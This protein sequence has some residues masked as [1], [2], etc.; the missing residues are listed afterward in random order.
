MKLAVYN[1]VAAILGASDM[2][3]G[4]GAVIA[5]SVRNGRQEVD[6]PE[7]EQLAKHSS[8]REFWAEE[9]GVGRE[10]DVRG[11]AGVL[12]GMARSERP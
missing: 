9:T 11:S 8:L 1:A 6:A 10:D 12:K 5:L 2:L 3:P 7:A 4:Y